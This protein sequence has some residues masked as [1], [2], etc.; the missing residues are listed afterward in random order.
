VVAVVRNTCPIHMDKMDE[1]RRAG[2]N[3]NTPFLK[4]LVSDRSL[5]TC[6]RDSVFPQLDNRA[7]AIQAENNL[8]RDI[9]RSN[10]RLAEVPS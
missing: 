3:H 10:N 5:C 8:R 7:Y 9:S 1:I 4:G 2:D 6:S